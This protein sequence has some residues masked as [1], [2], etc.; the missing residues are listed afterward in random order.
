MATK[1][2]RVSPFLRAFAL[3]E[4][5]AGADRPVSLNEATAGAGLP[6]PTVYRM[7]AMLEEA[8]CSSASPRAGA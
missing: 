5:I 7:L 3:L 4:Q 6:K 8:G 2:D 1:I